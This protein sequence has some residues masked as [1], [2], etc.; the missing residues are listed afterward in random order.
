ML[1]VL[2]ALS[3]G[4]SA[5]HLQ[6]A[7]RATPHGARAQAPVT[8]AKYDSEFLPTVTIEYCT[9]CNWML[10]SA[11]L[12]QEVLT[13]FNGTVAS[14]TLIPN[15]RGGVF[16]VAVVTTRG[17]AKSVWSREEEG[18]CVQ[19]CTQCERELER[20]VLSSTC[21]TSDSREIYAMPACV[22][23][24]ACRRFPE[25]KELKQRVRDILDPGMKLGHSDVASG[26]DSV[27]SPPPGGTSRKA[28]R[29]LWDVIRGDRSA[30]NR[31]GIDPRGG[32]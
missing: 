16:E 5:L 29:R 10:R 32:S 23:V 28:L 15:H 4:A 19:C 11:W 30:R 20:C 18:R 9:R 6:A 24:C 8:M 27:D 25:S 26:D 2:L 7:R 31:E 21:A 12:A 1:A 14:T 22:C 3:A 17:E 13:T